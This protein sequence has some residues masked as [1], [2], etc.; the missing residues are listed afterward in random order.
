MCLSLHVPTPLTNLRL[1]L[2]L[3]REAVK[4]AAAN[5]QTLSDFIRVSIER[6]IDRRQ[7]GAR[8]T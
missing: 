5:G 2:D 7:K 6:E 1:D 4:V 3:K 8:R